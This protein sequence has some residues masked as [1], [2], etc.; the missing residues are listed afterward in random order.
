MSLP[1]IG[2]HDAPEV[3]VS[4]EAD[5]EQVEHF[6]LEKIG[7]RPDW[8]QGIHACIVPREADLQPETLLRDRREQMVNDLEPWIA[9][10]PIDAGKIGKRVEVDL[11]IVL[12]RRARLSQGSA[13]DVDRQ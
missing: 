3:R 6:A 1:V 2:H 10:L 13:L 11:R 12:Q 4:V 8:R 9:G 5:P 7:S